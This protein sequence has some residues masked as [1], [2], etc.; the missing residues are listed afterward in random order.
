MKLRRDNHFTEN[1]G[2]RR[3]TLGI[4]RTIHNNDPAKWGLPIGSE[5]MI[6][7]LLEV[8]ALADPAWIGVLQNG[9]SC[10]IAGE[11][12]D[13]LCR[14]GEVEDVV[15]RKFLS[16]ELLEIFGEI[17]VERGSLMGILTVPQFLRERR[18]HGE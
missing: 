14:G 9:Q 4:H 11:L 18:V 7:G 17:S 15:V 16:V 12:L 5:C 2:D 1:L 10:R 8:C 3:G 6:P 13:Q